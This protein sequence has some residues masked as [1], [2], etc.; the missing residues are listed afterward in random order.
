MRWVPPTRA[1]RWALTVTV[2]ALGVPDTCL[3]LSPD[4]DCTRGVSPTR[5]WRWALTVTVR[6]GCPRHVHDAE[7]W[8]WLCTRWVSPTRA[9]RWALMV[10]VY[11]RG[12]PDTCMTLSPDG[13]CVCAGCPRHVHDSEP[14]CWLCTRWV[15]PTRAW[16]CALTVTVY[17]L[18]APDTCLT[19]CPDGDCV[20]AGCPRHVLDAVPWRWLC[21]RWVSPT[22]AWRWA[23]TV[24]VYAR[25]VPH[26]CM[27]LSPDGDCMRGVS[28]TRA[29]R[30]A[31]TVTV[32][33]LGVPDTCMTL[34]PDVDCV[35]AGCPRHV[36]DAVPWRWLYALG[37]PD[38]CMTLSPDDDC[39]STYLCCSSAYFLG[40]SVSRTR[41]IS[42]SYAR[43]VFA[44]NSF[45]DFL[46]SYIYQ[47]NI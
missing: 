28:P 46:V 11:A 42:S 32:Y 14:W 12:V 19:L 26:T 35:R 24:T 27:T 4:G 17:A 8:R 36:L 40:Y 1:W 15:S 30:W 23:L 18:G 16:R 2:Y 41:A 20:R 33:A 31:L 39:V 37:V 22:R 29:W 44:N 10:T 38:T 5:A 3:T 21:T 47:Q 6:A 9:W 25:G 13:D 43:S 7:P 34:N 45:T